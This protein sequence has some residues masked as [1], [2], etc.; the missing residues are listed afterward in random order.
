M[1]E[2]K[3]SLDESH[4]EELHNY[5]MLQRLRGKRDLKQVDRFKSRMSEN[6][7]NISR[8]MNP[9][10]ASQAQQQA[11]EKDRYLKALKA[12][13]YDKGEK[14]SKAQ[15]PSICSCGALAE[16]L[17]RG[18]RGE[19]VAMCASNCQFYKNE[20]DYEKALRDILHSISQ[21]NS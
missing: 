8:Y 3:S 4:L 1:V 18:K 6:K 5:S 10:A 20:K 17:A 12:L 21:F 13:V 11:K 14:K 19:I 7:E 2:H 16:N 9:T 15:I